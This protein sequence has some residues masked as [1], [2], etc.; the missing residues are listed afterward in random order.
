MK[1]T[2]LKSSAA[3]HSTVKHSANSIDFLQDGTRVIDINKLP[4]NIQKQVLSHATF[5]ILKEQAKQHLKAGQIDIAKYLR[6]FI[7]AQTPHTQVAYSKAIDDYI[8]YLHRVGVTSLLLAKAEVVDGYIE[9]LK[10]A[11]FK[12]NSIRLKM[13]AISSFYTQLKRYGH[14]KTNPVH[15]ARLPAK[16]YK[17]AFRETGSKQAVLGERDFLLLQQHAKGKLQLAIHLMGRYG[18]RVGALKSI[19]VKENYF[20]YISKGSKDGRKE[21]LA[22]TLHLLGG[23]AGKVGGKHSGEGGKHWDG[24]PM[25]TTGATLTETTT[26][27]S[28]AAMP[29]SAATLTETTTA[30]GTMPAETTAAHSATDPIP[31]P[32]GTAAAEEITTETAGTAAPHTSTAEITSTAATSTTRTNPKSVHKS[33]NGTT[34]AAT[35][36]R[37]SFNTQTVQKGLARLVHKL[38]CQNILANHCNCHDLRHFFAIT[39]YKQHRDIYRLKNELDHASLSVT[40]V[41]LQWLKIK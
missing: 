34:T 40:D 4:A 16:Q 11:K 21:L 8:E 20:T 29:P 17:K 37:L 31:T 35:V 26:T 3:K 10:G 13:S 27:S 39:H 41:Y 6:R 25:A 2:T 7:K 5:D 22:E 19:V 15:G 24:A 33:T 30:A 32:T 38:R 1:K 23:K 28:N 18:L 9:E 12:P 14:V 36:K